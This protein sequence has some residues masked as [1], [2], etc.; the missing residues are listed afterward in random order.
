MAKAK[1]KQGKSR[2]PAETKAS[3]GPGKPD[4]ASNWKDIEHFKPAEF[5]CKCEQLCDHAVAISTELVK[6]LDKVRDLMGIPI[7]ITSGTRC[8][9]HNQ[10]V[11]GKL[12][13]AH[14]QKHGTSHAVDVH[15]PN[16]AF[17]YAFLAAALPMFNRIGIGKDFIHVD[18]DPDLPPNVIWVY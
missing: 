13:S 12:R 4:P 16:S 6:K 11:G 5:T 9:K 18:D 17:R 15:C 7:T 1:S 10:K 8:E 3:E 14:T 2:A